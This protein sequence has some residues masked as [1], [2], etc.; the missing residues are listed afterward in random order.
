MDRP[1]VPDFD[2]LLDEGGDRRDAGAVAHRDQTAGP[3]R[4]RQVAD[5]GGDADPVAE[6]QLVVDDGGHLAVGRALDVELQ[7]GGAVGGG[8]GGGGEREVTPDPWQAADLDR[9]VLPG[10]VLVG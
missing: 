6:P 9:G 2:G 7:E 4:E 5:R 10:A 3:G 8:V 1:V